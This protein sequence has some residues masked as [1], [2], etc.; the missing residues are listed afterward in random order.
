MIDTMLGKALF[1]HKACLPQLLYRLFFLNYKEAKHK[2]LFS[3]CF[4]FSIICIPE[5][6]PAEF[7]HDS[8]ANICTLSIFQPPIHQLEQESI[9]LNNIWILFEHLT[10]RWEVCTALELTG[11]RDCLRSGHLEQW[12]PKL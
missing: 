3:S 12:L 10:V 7:T 9:G 8:W 4:I 1:S 6:C 5:L 2:K 11:V